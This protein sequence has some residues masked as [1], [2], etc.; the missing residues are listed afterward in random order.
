MRAANRQPPRYTRGAHATTDHRCN[1]LLGRTKR[2]SV[3]FERAPNAILPDIE[4]VMRTRRATDGV[5]P[6]Q[7]AADAIA[8]CGASSTRSLV[9]SISDGSKRGSRVKS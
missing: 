7:I 9:L 3:V 8:L 2:A 1:R 4:F 6:H 5:P